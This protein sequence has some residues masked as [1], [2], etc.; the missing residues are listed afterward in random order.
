LA[1]RYVF[2]AKDLGAANRPRSDASL[3]LLPHRETHDD[4][5]RE[6]VT[7][8]IVTKRGD[9][10]RLA[11]P[12]TAREEEILKGQDI[13]IVHLRAKGLSWRDIGK[14]TRMSTSN[15]HYRYHRLPR[16]VR[17]EYARL[18]PLG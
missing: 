1:R 2:A 17:E 7:M 11:A 9:A 3:N 8:S 5:E 15:A 18:T 12:L 16:D 6:D 13:T 4:P 14:F 10:I